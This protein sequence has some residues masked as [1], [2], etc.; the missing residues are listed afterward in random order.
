M[1]VRRAILKS[2]SQVIT[3]Q[4]DKSSKEKNSAIE[5]YL[6]TDRRME[7]YFEGFLVKNIARLDNEHDN[8]LAKYVAHGLPVPQK[9]YLKY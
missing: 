5:K 3:C 8:M 6:D 7:A 2:D 4:V 9:Y 1:G